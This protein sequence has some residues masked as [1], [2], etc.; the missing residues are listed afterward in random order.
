MVLH[1][2]LGD[3]HDA[4][5]EKKLIEAIYLEN[6]ND[7]LIDET[8]EDDKTLSLARVRGFHVIIFQKKIVNSPISTINNFIDHAIIT[9]KYLTIFQQIEMF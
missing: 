2:F 4:T 5:E 6:N 8:Y 7:L 3:S 1:A 9:Q